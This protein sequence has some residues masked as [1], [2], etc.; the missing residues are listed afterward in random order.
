MSYTP[1]PPHITTSQKNRDPF[2]TDQKIPTKNSQRLH[3][4]HFITTDLTPYKCR[5]FSRKRPSNWGGQ[6]KKSKKKCCHPISQ[7]LYPT[8]PA[9]VPRYTCAKTKIVNRFKNRTQNV[10]ETKNWNSETKKTVKRTKICKMNMCE[11]KKLWTD[12]W[13]NTVCR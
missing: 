7:D 13:K 12:L 6:N 9:A 11:R 4:H 8:T 1:S 3:N 5:A 10:C 2:T